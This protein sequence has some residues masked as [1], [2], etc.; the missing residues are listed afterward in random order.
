[1]RWIKAMTLIGGVLAAGA[2]A[3]GE[4]GLDY[5]W[6]AVGIGPNGAWGYSHSQYSEREARNVVQSECGGNCDVVQT[7]YNTCGALSEGSEGN[8]GF[9]WA[10][11]RDAAEETSIGYC[12]DHGGGCRVRV[13]ACSR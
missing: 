11:T 12:E 8:W 4:C 3:A 10:N 6:G 13:W 1:M 9:G 5:C 2:S 7:F